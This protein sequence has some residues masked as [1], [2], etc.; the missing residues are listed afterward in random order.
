MD[1][2]Q[3]ARLSALVEEANEGD[4][5][6]LSPCIFEPRYLFRV[7]GA[8]APLDIEIDGAMKV[9]HFRREGR[10]VGGLGFATECIRGDLCDL[11]RELHPSATFKDGC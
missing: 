5:G 4:C 7:H 9:W 8:G 1:S 3:I 10:T 2:T 11:I 6:F